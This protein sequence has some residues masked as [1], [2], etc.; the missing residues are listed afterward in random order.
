MEA[1]LKRLEAQFDRVEAD[2]DAEGA[3]GKQPRDNPKV[4]DGRGPAR[5]DKERTPDPAAPTR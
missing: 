2:L 5:P 4:P 1:H 3:A